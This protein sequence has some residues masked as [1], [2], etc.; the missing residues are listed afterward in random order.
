MNVPKSASTTGT[1]VSSPE[2]PRFIGEI[3]AGVR[4]A[5]FVVLLVLALVVPAA[6]GLFSALA[7]SSRG[8]IVCYVPEVDCEPVITNSPE[9][10]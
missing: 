4:E 3:A 5:R 10:P 1:A 6:L 7:I 9:S 2:G 8:P